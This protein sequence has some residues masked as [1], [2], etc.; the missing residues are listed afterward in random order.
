MGVRWSRMSWIERNELWGRW[1]R[2]ESL[3]DI[4][5]GLRRAPSVVYAV[6]GAEGGV[7][8]RN[9]NTNGLLRQYLP[10]A[11]DLS[12]YSQSQLDVIALRL[13]T[14]PRMTLGYQTPAAKLAEIVAA[15]G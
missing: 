14:R 3:R 11:A 15:T 4:A 12:R 1:R 2:G 6:V 8:P 9:E 10:P 7:A 5:Q 13:N